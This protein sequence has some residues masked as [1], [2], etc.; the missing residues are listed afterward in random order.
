MAVRRVP[1]R[2]G[3]RSSP[4]GDA[5]TRGVGPW[6][7]L[8][9]EAFQR[10][11]EIR[12]QSDKWN[13]EPGPPPNHDIIVPRLQASRGRKPHDFPELAAQA[14]ALDRAADLARH[15]E[16]HAHRSAVA[17]AAFLDN[18]SGRRDARPRRGGSQEIPASLQTF[19][20]HRKYPQSTGGKRGSC[21][22]ALAAAGPAGVEHLAAARRRHAGTEAVTALAHE[23]A[24]LIGP[25]H[26]ILAEDRFTE[27]RSAPG[28]PAPGIRQ[29]NSATRVAA[30]VSGGV[31]GSCAYIRERGGC[32]NA[33]GKECGPVPEP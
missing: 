18:E 19:D 7:P 28:L 25:L 17:A 33:E 32:V 3:R 27:V 24:R 2:L 4:V 8:L 6:P 9:F 14:V 20:R 1:D 21:T 31:A 5:A 22:Q 16:A 26:G 11:R 15:G 23:L 29:C 12:G 10:T 13:F 30:A